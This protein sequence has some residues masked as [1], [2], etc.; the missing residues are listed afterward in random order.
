MT[1]E[2]IS[3]LT[4]AGII[5]FGGLAVLLFLEIVDTNM[6]EKGIFEL[7][8]PISHFINPEYEY[9]PPIIRQQ[10]IVEIPVILD[11]QNGT[12]K[13]T[14]FGITGE[15][16]L[17][18]KATALSSQN[19]IKVNATMNFPWLEEEWRHF[20]EEEFR[21]TLENKYVSVGDS[22][23]KSEEDLWI[24]LEDQYFLVFPFAQ[25]YPRNQTSNTYFSAMFPIEKNIET[26]QYLGGRII[27]Y[28]FHGEKPFFELFTR[29]ELLQI[30]EG[31]TTAYIAGSTIDET[32][33]GEP[34]LIIEP[35]S[36]TTILKTNILIIALTS[37]VISFMIVQLRF[38]LLK[39]N[40]I[41]VRGGQVRLGKERQSEHTKIDNKFS[42]IKWKKFV[43]TF[44]GL[45][46]AL[47]IA[48]I[49]AS[50]TS[51]ES[52]TQKIGTISSVLALFFA[53]YIAIWAAKTG[54]I[55]KQEVKRKTN[56]AKEEIYSTLRTIAETRKQRERI[57]T[58][59][60]LALSD[61]DL[62]TEIRFMNHKLKRVIESL[63]FVLS[64]HSEYLPSKFVSRIN[65]AINGYDFILGR[66][67][68]F[69][70]ENDD[71]NKVLAGNIEGFIEELKAI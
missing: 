48:L 36:V 62:H 23:I 3:I 2:V 53:V 24:E 71:P 65:D 28:P 6:A 19:P 64:L 9:A 58:I 61:S 68:I 34:L 66:L 33:Q 49:G 15:V 30:A 63:Q 18:F 13:S 14:T 10:D 26:K 1:K 70:L 45:M 39:E 50:W 27:M 12:T 41:Q 16:K 69:P 38:H 43:V 57:R 8:F 56:H 25:N 37:T 54:Y 42:N 5:F 21:V 17:V 47:V 52:T 29:D 20:L 51:P 7:G 22:F 40:F 60:P 35:S 59:N 55:K 31:G 67:G 44:W 11:F 46:V 32:L 4:L